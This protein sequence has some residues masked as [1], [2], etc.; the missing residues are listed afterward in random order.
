MNKA[1]HEFLLYLQYEK[2]Y[3]PR[4]IASYRI[5]VSIFHEFLAKHNILFDDVSV[6][7]IRDFLEE[8][9]LSGLS[10]A[11]LRRRVVALRRYYSFLVGA[12]YTSINPFVF[13]DAP[14]A[15]IRY[16]KILSQDQVEDLLNEE[17]FVKYYLSERDEAIIFTLAT[18]GI[19]VSELTNLK[20]QDIDF[21]NRILHIFGKGNKERLVPFSKKCRDRL[22]YYIKEFRPLLSSKDK[23]P[24]TNTVFLSY[25]G[26]PLDSRS[27]EF[28]LK[29]YENKTHHY[30]DLHPHKLRHSFA[31]ALL[32][33]GADLRLIQDLLGHESINTTQIYTHVSQKTITQQYRT[34]HPRAKKKV[35][36]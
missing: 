14:K 24:P 35:D 27:V 7:N 36:K 19:R 26:K 5:D 29:K 28:I 8:Q 20:L 21:E 23:A 17:K 10:K 18:T 11:T 12:K 22:E 4:T 3:S 34:F 15:S 33:R 9:I 32:E 30:F 13:V 31:T 25:R 2:L 16:P 1:L 6:Q